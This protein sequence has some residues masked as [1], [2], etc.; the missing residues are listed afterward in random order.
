MAA[1]GSDGNGLQLEKVRLT[2][3]SCFRASSKKID[4]YS[5]SLNSMVISSFKCPKIIFLWVKLNA[6][7]FRTVYTKNLR[8]PRERAPLTS[9]ALML[10]GLV[11]T[12]MHVYTLTDSL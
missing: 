6:A 1:D 8:N 2:F 4:I 12:C 7:N 9:F 5:R 11:H 3:S 10:R